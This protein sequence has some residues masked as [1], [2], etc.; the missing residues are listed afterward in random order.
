L[1]INNDEDTV[2]QPGPRRDREVSKL[3]DVEASMIDDHEL[4]SGPGSK[5]EA[6]IPLAHRAPAQV[7]RHD[8]AHFG[9][10]SP[11]C[12]TSVR[13][14]VLEP[15]SPTVSFTSDYVDQNML[16]HA[17]SGF[18][19]DADGEFQQHK[20]AIHVVQHRPED[21][22]KHFAHAMLGDTCQA[23]SLESKLAKSGSRSVTT[24]D[25]TAY[26]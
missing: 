1:T 17:V 20:T 8:A 5:T 18:G 16:L 21:Q 2:L 10:S 7:R 4:E 12:E 24:A 25:P 11:S 15:S 9:I 3:P 14:R 19:S 23:D 13:P 22:C 26:I 6:Q